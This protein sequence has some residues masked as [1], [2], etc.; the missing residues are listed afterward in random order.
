MIVIGLKGLTPLRTARLSTQL[1]S[2]IILTFAVDWALKTNYPSI[3]P[4]IQPSPPPSLPLSIYLASYLSIYLPIYL[5]AAAAAL[6]SNPVWERKMHVCMQR[7]VR[8]DARHLVD[9]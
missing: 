1:I 2:L 4:A 5:T 6:K 7:T 3:Q 8:L 9:Q